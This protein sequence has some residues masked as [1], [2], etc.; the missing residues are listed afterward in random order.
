MTVVDDTVQDVAVAEV[1][2]EDILP[3][4]VD[5]DVVLRG[6][7]R[8][9]VQRHLHA[10]DAELRLLTTDRD[11]AVLRA[12]DLARQVEAQRREIADLRSRLDRVC[13]AP[14]DTE[15]LTERL[16]RMVELACAE[17]A[18]ITSSARAAADQSWQ[19]T[20]LATA[21][22]R[23]RCDR[24]ASELDARR[25]QM[26][27]EHQELLRQAHVQVRAIAERAA[28]R[29]AELDERAAAQRRLV[30]DD[31][32]IAMAARRK[33]TL[34]DLAALRASAHAEADRLL[35]EARDRSRRQIADAR[36]QVDDL[37]ALRQRIA[38]QLRS[39]GELLEQSCGLLQPLPEESPV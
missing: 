29:R 32:Q 22:L 6:F 38:A 28:A 27:H 13:R 10:V 11:A 21:R 30:E 15:G 26:E 24:L 17:A 20:R 34:A 25:R 14:V 4:A 12:D 2:A 39:A 5:F 8:Y 33:E 37:I 19:S 1:A 36:H 16:R 23:E 18:E 31:F 35:A 9:Q 3:L 7:D